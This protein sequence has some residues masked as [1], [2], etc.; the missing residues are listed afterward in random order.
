MQPA[1]PNSHRT[2]KSKVSLGNGD[3]Y[4][5]EWDEEGFRD[6]EGVLEY[7]DGALYEGYFRRGKCHG[8]GR[9]ISAAGDVYTGDWSEGKVHGQ[10]HYAVKG[11]PVYEG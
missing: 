10:G 2:K 4:E 9:L 1:S 11:G 3:M 6:G 7:A 5:G 8:K